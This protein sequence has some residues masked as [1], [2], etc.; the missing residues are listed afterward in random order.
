[1]VARL[2]RTADQTKTLAEFDR[3]IQDVRQLAS[4]YDRWS[5]VLTARRRDSLHLVLQS[6]SAIFAIVL[7]V[8]LI[9]RAIRHS[10]RHRTTDRRRLHQLRLMA[11]IAVQV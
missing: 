6:A 2:R 5:R 4:I 1:V 3:R 9:D 11:I 8:I 7:I 10:F